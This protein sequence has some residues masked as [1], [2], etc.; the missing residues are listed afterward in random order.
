MTQSAFVIVRTQLKSIIDGIATA[1]KIGAVYDYL[2]EEVTTTPTVAI[3]DDT[4]GEEYDSSTKN[5]VNINYTVRVMVEKTTALSTQITKLLTLVDAILEELRRSSNSS[6]GGN[7]NYFMFESIT[8][9]AV[10]F[11][12]DRDLLFKDIK[13]STKMFKTV[14]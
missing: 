1:A 14:C 6:L 11:V 2:P 7:V 3:F 8:P 12:A 4:S 9:T 13:I 10:G 5:L